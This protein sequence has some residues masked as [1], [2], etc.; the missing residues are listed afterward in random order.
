VHQDNFYFGCNNDEKVIAVWLALDDANVE[1]GC[2]F[3]GKGTNQ[4]SII[5][6]SA[7]KKEP[8]NYRF[9]K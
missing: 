2:L 8:F 3:Y 4:S 5:N 6:H 7:S 9:R 1:N